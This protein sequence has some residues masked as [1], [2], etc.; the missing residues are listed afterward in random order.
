VQLEH[1]LLGAAQELQGDGANE[2]QV[3]HELGA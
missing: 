3:L 2:A 1:E